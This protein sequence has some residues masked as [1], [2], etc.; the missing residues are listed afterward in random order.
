MEQSFV[1]ISCLM[2]VVFYLAISLQFTIIYFSISENVIY[3]KKSQLRVCFYR[4][5][6]TKRRSLHNSNA[7]PMLIRVFVLSRS[8]WCLAWRASADKFFCCFLY[9]FGVCVGVCVVLE[10]GRFLVL[11]DSMSL[12]AVPS[13]R[14]YIKRREARERACTS[15]P[16][17][18][19][20]N[21]T[22]RLHIKIGI[23]AFRGN[24]K[25]RKVDHC[26]VWLQPLHRQAIKKGFI[27]QKK[28][29]T[30]PLMFS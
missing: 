2:Y 15:H 27:L 13:H 30:A 12:A 20:E 16:V 26:N 18:F 6:K 19:A 28:L 22:R 9:I 10:A 25:T 29:H 17:D 14:L 8:D 23:L 1:F 3:Q 21:P 4:L 7:L 5:P 24:S 11:S